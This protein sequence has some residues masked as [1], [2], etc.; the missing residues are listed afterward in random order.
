MNKPM[1]YNSN[2]IKSI[3]CESISKPTDSNNM[4]VNVTC[5]FL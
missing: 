2:N 4:F 5:K 3:L 1:K